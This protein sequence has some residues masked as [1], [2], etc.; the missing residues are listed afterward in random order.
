MIR[1]SHYQ[2]YF[3]S[4]EIKRF[5]CH[6]I[7]TKAELSQEM[8]LVPN[9]KIFCNVYGLIDQVCFHCKLLLRVGFVLEQIYESLLALS[10]MFDELELLVEAGI[11]N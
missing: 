2:V 11:N 3:T 8:D 5:Q 1:E 7:V 6:N 10:Y 4:G 9:G